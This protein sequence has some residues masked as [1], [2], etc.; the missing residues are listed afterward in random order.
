[1]LR[2]DRAT[3]FVGVRVHLALGYCPSPGRRYRLT[4][5]SCPRRWLNVVS[6]DGCWNQSRCVSHRQSDEANPGIGTRASGEPPVL[7]PSRLA[8]SGNM[9]VNDAITDLDETRPTARVAKPPATLCHA[10]TRLR[11][12]CSW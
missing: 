8:L 9:N 11:L 3:G 4:W 2:L 1:M 6:D 10:A 7:S 5:T 12:I